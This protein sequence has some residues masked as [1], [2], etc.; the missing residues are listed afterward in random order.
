MAL[1]LLVEWRRDWQE[2]FKDVFDDE[3]YTTIMVED[4][5][6]ALAHLAHTQVD[7]IITNYLM[8]KTAK[9]NGLDF[10]EQLQANPVY[11]HIPIL[12]QSGDP[13]IETDVFAAGASAF[14]PKDQF[15]PSEMT[16]LINQCLRK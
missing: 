4:G 6:Q 3:G 1:I 5:H 9:M 2:I 11:K 8:P 13:T 12:V 16:T 15:N 14:I 7:L 10:I